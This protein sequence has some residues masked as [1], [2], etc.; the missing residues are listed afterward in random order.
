[1][2]AA[3][4][5][6]TTWPLQR[7]PAPRRA[8]LLTIAAVLGV[9]LALTCF[10]QF[11][12]PRQPET[13][14]PPALWLARE[15]GGL[16]NP[17][18]TASVTIQLIV[19][20]GLLIL[21]CRFRP[22]EIGLDTAKLPAA[23]GLTLAIWAAAQIVQLILLALVGQEIGINPDWTGPEWRWAAGRW[24][25]HL[26]AND[27][28]EE[29][30]FRGFLL[31]QCVLLA[32]KWLPHARPALQVSFAVVVSGGLFA[33][34]HVPYNFNQ[35]IGQWL[36]LFHLTAGII[37]AGVYLRTGNLFLTMGVHTLMNNV[38]PLLEDT[39]DLGKGIV[40]IGT[41]AAVICGPRMFDWL[42]WRTRPSGAAPSRAQTVGAAVC[43]V[44][45]LAA[46]VGAAL[47][48][49]AYARPAWIALAKKDPVELAELPE[50]LRDYRIVLVGENH[51]FI[52]P[53][54][55]VKGL[56]AGAEGDRRFT[57]L[58]VEW[59]VSEQSNINR[60]LGGDDALLEQ[61]QREKGVT[62]EY[63]SV[64]TFVRDH[65]RAHPQHPIVV[66]PIDMPR[67]KI[68][69]VQDG[70]AP[71]RDRHMFDQV[72][73]ILAA[74][75]NARVLVYCGALH[76]A[77][78]GLGRVPTKEGDKVQVPTLGAMLHERHSAR[79]VSVKIL[80]PNDPMWRELY[81]RRIFPQPVAIR[82]TP[83]WPEL[84]KLVLR[85]DDYPD[86]ASATKSIA[87]AYDYAVWWPTSRA[88]TGVK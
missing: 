9:Y 3:A 35:P 76:A 46:W 67:P 25:G 43:I 64:W 33:L 14:F 86:A 1:M 66:R 23:L 38:A 62:A 2:P 69:F 80:S 73:K 61:F 27:A 36:L 41:L 79:L 70:V 30:F 87:Q 31:T 82:L 4:E 39:D 71:Q 50:L 68:A 83:E 65:N 74:D 19:I 42:R 20:G 49:R 13:W 17:S 16:I 24:L 5:T 6:P 60:Y 81:R 55:T 34:I 8:A 54:E 37:F 40:G 15:T 85:D 26:L 52:E 7:I 48:S 84:G 22:S 51:G 72:E 75:G 58:A 29:V 57:H 63:I 44:A 11:L 12:F 47:Y 45:V 78:C 28:L 77:K 88:G 10:F 59:Y 56:L 21:V 53:P 18:F 32:G